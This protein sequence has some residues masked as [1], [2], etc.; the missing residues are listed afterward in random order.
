MRSMEVK[1][2]DVL[3]NVPKWF[4]G[5]M[6]FTMTM[7][8][9]LSVFDPTNGSIGVPILWVVICWIAFHEGHARSLAKNVI[10]DH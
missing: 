7:V 8:L 4:F 3:D 2:S 6:V 1:I 10:H 9:A 5:V